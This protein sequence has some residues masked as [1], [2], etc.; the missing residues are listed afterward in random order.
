MTAS[1]DTYSP[2]PS[3]LP[4]FPQTPLS[5]N[6]VAR[7]RISI[8]C[9]SS[10]SIVASILFPASPIDPALKPAS[11]AHQTP[12]L[13]RFDSPSVDP[14]IPR[15]PSTDDDIPK[16]FSPV[17]PELSSIGKFPSSDYRDNFPGSVSLSTS[18]PGLAALASVASA[19]TSNLRYVCIQVERDD[20]PR[21]T[22]SFVEETSCSPTRDAAHSYLWAIWTWVG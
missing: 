6:S 11:S 20:E 15:P 14:S 3:S 5:F 13:S 16:R 2:T 9:L 10:P 8:D 12:E 21:D 7:G 17:L 4:L 1:R 22:V 18:L 19:P